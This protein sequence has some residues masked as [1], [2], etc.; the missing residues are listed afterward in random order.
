MKKLIPILVLAAAIGFGV[1]TYLFSKGHDDTADEAAAFSMTADNIVQEFLDDETGSNAKFIDQV[2]EISGPVFD[3]EKTDGKVTGIKISSDESYV[4]SCSFQE[5]I[6]S[7]EITDQIKVKGV[8]S[9]FNGD[10]ES[11]LPG[12][13]VELKRSVIVK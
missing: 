6:E 5:P 11:M 1:G 13:V 8:C 12:G 4:V 2:V 3:I 10:A 7:S 9:G